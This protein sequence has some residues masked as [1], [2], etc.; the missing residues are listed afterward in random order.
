[1]PTRASCDTFES[2][3]DVAATP[4]RMLRELQRAGT[5]SSTTSPSRGAAM[6]PS[7]SMAMPRTSPFRTALSLRALRPI[8]VVASCRLTAASACSEVSTVQFLLCITLSHVLARSRTHHFGICSRQLTHADLYIDNKTRNPKVKGVNDFQNNVIYNWG[9]GGGYIASGGDGQ[10]YANIVN[11][12]FISGPSTSVTAFTR[13]NANFH[14][15]VSNNFYD[16]DRNGKLDGSALCESTTCYSDMD[17]VTTQYDYSAPAKL[18]T[19]EEAVNFVLNSTG[20]TY[21]A[22]DSVDQLLVEQV[23]S[24]GKDGALISNEDDIGGVGTI[25]GGTAP[26]DTDGDGIPDAWETANGLDP[27]DATD[28]MKISESGYANIEVY[29]N[30]LVPSTYA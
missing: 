6:R 25:L 26:K 11:N 22:R 15:F 8:A 17:I 1:M 14:G 21:P 30:S 16:S 23:R 5:S 12:Y 7:A 19:P 4:E 3:W 18:F 20:T 29:I 9:G 28:A 24:F 10:S 13:G 2:A 27:N